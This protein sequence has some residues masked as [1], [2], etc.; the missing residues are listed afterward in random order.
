MY[1]QLRHPH[2]QLSYEAV[3]LNANSAFLLMARETTT[4]L[5]GQ[6]VSTTMKD[7]GRQSCGLLCLPAYLPYRPGCSIGMVSEKCV[8]CL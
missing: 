2:I 8:A 1:M 5:K 4:A 3:V 6:M 7:P